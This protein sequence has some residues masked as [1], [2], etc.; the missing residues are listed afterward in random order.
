[1]KLG[2]ADSVQ[3]HTELC[4]KIEFEQ[5]PLYEDRGVIVEHIRAGSEECWER[6]ECGNW[7][8]LKRDWKVRKWRQNTDFSFNKSGCERK[9]CCGGGINKDVRMRGGLVLFC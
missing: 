8:R 9:E 2:V 7:N 5:C 1:M 6:G 4:S 3:E